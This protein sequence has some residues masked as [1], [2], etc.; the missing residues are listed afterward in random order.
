MR[1]LA[2]GLWCYSISWTLTAWVQAIG[3]ADVPAKAAVLGLILHIPFNWFFIDVLNWGYLGCAVATVCFQV[4]QP[5]FL[6]AYLFGSAHGRKRV[7][8]CTG[9]QAIGRTRLSFWNEF[10]IAIFSIR[11]YIQYLALALPGI[12]IISEWWASETSI[13]LSGRLEPSPEAALGGTC[14]T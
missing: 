5:L 3:M 11:G 14:Y 1:V 6:L 7:L 9:G 13:F 10:F 4:I 8:E 12:V 2:P